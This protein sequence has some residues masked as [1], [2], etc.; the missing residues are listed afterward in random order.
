PDLVDAVGSCRGVVLVD[1]LG[2]WVAGAPDL[3]VDADG[4]CAA[5]AARHGDT[6]VVSEEVGLGVHPS[7]EAGR[8]FRDV[9][10]LVNQVVAAA[11]DEV[12]LVVA[13]RTLALGAGLLGEEDR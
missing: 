7:S 6:V 4:F 10:G 2:T 3:V 9:L 12:L 13:G 11:A 5:L 1:A 8:H